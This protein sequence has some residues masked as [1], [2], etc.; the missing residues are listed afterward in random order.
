M[1]D[2]T[3]D[4]EPKATVGLANA[5]KTGMDFSIAMH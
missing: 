4:K 2:F 5:I 1:I 3:I